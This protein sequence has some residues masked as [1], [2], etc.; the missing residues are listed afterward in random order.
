M[1]CHAGPNAIETGLVLCLDANNTKS[2]PGTGTT[3]FDISGQGNNGTSTDI[4][5]SLEDSGTAVRLDNTNLIQVVFGQPINKYNFTLSYW[6][7]STAVPAANYRR[8]WRLVEPNASHGYYFIADTREVATPYLL[9]Y[10]KD[11][12][13]SNWDTRTML[14]I[15]DFANYQW[16]YYDLVM[17]AENDWKSYRNGVLLGTNTTP[18]QDLSSYGD[19]TK[20]E[21]GGVDTKFNIAGIRMYNRPLTSTEI[22]TNFQAFR[23]RF[24]L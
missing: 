20:L 11:Y 1:S 19:I 24:G 10:V 3:W 22:L 2:Y 21:I 7:R 14:S 17:Y 6:G 8:I 23:S 12:S 18:S 5:T 15:S 4:V 9:H 13:T 16:N